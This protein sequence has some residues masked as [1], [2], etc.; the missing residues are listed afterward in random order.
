M[1]RD[2]LDLLAFT[3]MFALCLTW[4]FNQ[5]LAKIAN[6]GIS[7]LLQAGLRSAGAAL[8]VWAWTA[9]R[10]IRLFDRDGSLV[11]GVIAGLLF[12]GEFALI[13]W[14]LEFT[15][16]SRTVIFVYSSPFVVAL[17]V[18]LFV[19]GERLR[20]VQVIGLMGA[21]A[22]VALAFSGA[23]ALPTN[24]QL[25]GDSMEL[26]AGIL[27]GATTVL[28]KATRLARI[29]PAKTLFYQLAVS[30]VVL[31]AIAWALGEPGIFEPTAV[32][33][34]SVLFQTVVV[35]FIS[36]LAWFWLIAN[37]PAGRLASFTFLTPLFGVAAGRAVL[38]E[39]L[40]SDL[41]IALALVGIGI[42]LV[43]RPPLPAKPLAP[44]LKEAR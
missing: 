16:A 33:V 19:P 1:R 40:S 11:P 35:A 44:G 39:P 5:V 3:V 14:G 22:G 25:I 24:R 37:Y 34:G 28:V 17:G 29:A 18:H 8:L 21:F 12:A 13:F 15:T 32:V 26:G 38:A 10:G 7:P 6:E 30:A 9:W 4:G 27:W 41:V 43:N 20:A 2:R 36:Y 23:L 31:P 42:Y